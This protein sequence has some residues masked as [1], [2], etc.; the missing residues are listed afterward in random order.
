[1]HFPTDFY[2]HLKEQIY[3]WI[4]GGM[5]R[6]TFLDIWVVAVNNRVFARSWNKS[7]QSWFTAFLETG[8]GQLKYGDNIIDVTGKKLSSNAEIQEKINQAYLSRYN[9]KENNFYAEGIVQPEY[10]DYT[11]EFFYAENITNI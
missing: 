10:L 6:E 3:T 8:V 2:T 9:Q 11:M 5:E 7:P 4:K 1:M